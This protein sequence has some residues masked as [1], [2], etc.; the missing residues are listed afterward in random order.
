MS[1]ENKSV[2]KEIEEM[3]KELK[4]VATSEHDEEETQICHKS[5]DRIWVDSSDLDWLADEV[6]NTTAK[7]L[8]RIMK[9]S[10]DF[11]GGYYYI[12]L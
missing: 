1:Q 11:Q 10:I 2:S 5:D 12:D 3:C 8:R 6:E 7:K 4:R 9:Y